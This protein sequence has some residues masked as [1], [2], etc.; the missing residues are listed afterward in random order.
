MF[1]NFQSINT[2]NIDAIFIVQYMSGSPPLSSFIVTFSSLSPPA[3]FN[4]V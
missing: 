4:T 2:M 1:L 3:S